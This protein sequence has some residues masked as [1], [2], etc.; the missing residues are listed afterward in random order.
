[1]TYPNVAGIKPGQGQPR[2]TCRRVGYGCCEQ[3]YRPVDSWHGGCVVN[4]IQ[5]RAEAV[6]LLQELGLKEYQARCFLTLTQLSTGTAKQI[7]NL[8]EVPRTRVYDAI[9]VLEGHGLV[10]VQDLNPKRF[11][12]VSIDEAV[13]ILRQQFDS[14]IDALQSRLERLNLE[15]EADGEDDVHEVWGLTGAAAIESRTQV[16]LKEAEE[17]I[18][19]LV[20]DEGL[21]TDALFE[22]LHAAIDR[23][24]DV[25]VGGKTDAVVSKLDTE[26]SSVRVFETELDWLVGPGS[27]DAV[28]IGRLLLVDHATLLVSTFYP[29]DGHG[30]SNEQAIFARGLENGVVVLIR[31]LITSGFF[32]R[33]EPGH[34]AK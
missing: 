33:A 1:M 23:G 9:N 30:E 17:E 32:P 20:V 11:R 24:V 2:F 21:L 7:S 26:L 3:H 14:R 13:S 15:V 10:E 5:T 6:N 28:A 19:L 12:A 31:R 25:V 22:R 29:G 8:S 34:V 16:V 18:V 27:D 4:Q